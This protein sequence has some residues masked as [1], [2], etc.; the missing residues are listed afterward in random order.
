MTNQEKEFD[1]NAFIQHSEVTRKDMDLPTLPFSFIDDW[2][3]K[4]GELAAIKWLE[5]YTMGDRSSDQKIRAKV[6]RSMTKLAKYWGIGTTKLYDKIIIPLWNYGLIELVEHE[7][8]NTNPNATKPINIVVNHSPWNEKKNMR[9]PLEKKRDY[10]TQWKSKSRVHHLNRKKDSEGVSQDKKGGFPKQEG[11]VSQNG[12]GGFPEMGNNNNTLKPLLKD[13][14]NNNKKD[15][16][17]SSSSNK[18]QIIQDLSNQFSPE[19]V[20]AAQELLEQK[21]FDTT[22]TTQ[23]KASLMLMIKDIEKQKTKRERTVSYLEPV[24][25]WFYENEKITEQQPHADLEKARIDEERRRLVAEL[26]RSSN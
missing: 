1:P 21:D 3:P 13:P 24:P 9:K 22:T 16:N 15:I 2:V 20:Q 10:A 6:P 14:I 7:G 23:Y 26:K 19:V 4:I 5:L 12:K 17:K 8:D 11:G 25:E 18:E